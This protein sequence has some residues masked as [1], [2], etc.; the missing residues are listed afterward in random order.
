MTEG[1]TPQEPQR[2]TLDTIDTGVTAGRIGGG[3]ALR[4]AQ[5]AQLDSER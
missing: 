1:R 3:G 2:K 5:L 4:P